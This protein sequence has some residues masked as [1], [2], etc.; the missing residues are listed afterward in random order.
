MRH[1]LLVPLLLLALVPAANA[2]DTTNM[3]VTGGKLALVRCSTRTAATSTRLHALRAGG[4]G[5]GSS[6]MS[7]VAVDVDVQSVLSLS[8]EHSSLSSGIP[9]TGNTPAVLG[10]QLTVVSNSATGYAISVHRS[11]FTRRRGRAAGARQSRPPR[12]PP[13]RLNL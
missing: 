10:N 8:L 6:T 5:S 2:S 4:G 7:D 3:A 12:W 9:S 11:A 1:L 13:F